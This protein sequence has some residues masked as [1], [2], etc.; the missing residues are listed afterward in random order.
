MQDTGSPR[1]KTNLT[2]NDDT[3]EK[4]PE[5]ENAPAEFS[6]Q[7]LLPLASDDTIRPISELE[8]ESHENYYE[9]V[10]KVDTSAI[11][12][13]KQEWIYNVCGMANVDSFTA[14]PK[15]QLLFSLEFNRQPQSLYFLVFLLS[16][17]WPTKWSTKCFLR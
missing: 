3:L 15:V 2:Y 13:I 12:P 9:L 8:A 16:S 4:E 6:R 17:I 1:K 5:A 10:D 11:A 14:I 7:R